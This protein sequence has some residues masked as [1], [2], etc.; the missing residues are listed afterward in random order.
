MSKNRR[1][2]NLL[3]LRLPIFIAL[4]TSGCATYTAPQGWLPTAEQAQR[5][6]HGAWLG[7]RYTTPGQ[8][9]E[10][11]LEGELIAVGDSA[12]YLLGTF[13]VTRVPARLITVA[14]LEFHDYSLHGH[15]TW[16][17]VG[18]LSTVTH[19]LFLLISLPVWLTAGGIN[20]VALSE[21]GQNYSVTPDSGW[22]TE[23]SQYARFPQGL[24]PGL[25]LKDLRKK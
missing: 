22:W 5:T 1:S 20:G 9:T 11:A 21:A 15:I 19:G 2:L 10:S 4:L 17:A 24:P 6:T 23:A 18:A 14:Q 8:S 25:E 13:G 12:I 16:T 3:L 7:I